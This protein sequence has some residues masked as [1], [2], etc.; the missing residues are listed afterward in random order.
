[1]KH[2]FVFLFALGFFLWGFTPAS[3]TLTTVYDT[4]YNVD[5]WYEWDL[6]E[7]L[8]QNPSAPSPGGSFSGAGDI[9]DYYYSSFTRIDDAFDRFW[10]DLNGGVE[11]TAKYTSNT[12]DFGYS[13]NENTGSG[14]T[15]LI[16][17]AAVGNTNTF[18]IDNSDLFVW[19]LGGAGAVK[20]SN[21][22]LNG[23]TDRMVTFL[24]NGIWN[25]PDNQSQGSY[26]PGVPTYVIGFED[27]TDY[28]YQDLVVQV[29][30]TAPV[31]EPTTMLL[32]GAGLLGLAGVGRRFRK[33]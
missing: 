21:P 22:A 7:G 14:I 24:V 6:V 25:D 18:D 5:P 10:L 16:D 9:M 1:M 27:G 26:A 2:F 23:G 32:L 31:P 17:N 20:Y 8:S 12:L 29:S 28:D 13:L 33:H 30:N 11:V 15:W 3:A 19:A 4:T